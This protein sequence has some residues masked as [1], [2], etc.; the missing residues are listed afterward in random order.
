MLW[1]VWC[2]DGYYRFSCFR[3][4]RHTHTYANK[5]ERSLSR[6]HPGFSSYFVY[7][8]YDSTL[9][10]HLVYYHIISIWCLKYD[11][12]TLETSLH[13][14][15][16]HPGWALLLVILKMKSSRLLNFMFW[17]ILVKSSLVYLKSILLNS[18][19]QDRGLEYG[20]KSNNFDWRTCSL[21]PVQ[22]WHFRGITFPACDS[23]R[24]F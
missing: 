22:P 4:K 19:S 8:L 16:L 17:P 15:Y 6:W 24:Q 21:S 10:S 9:I 12:P 13:I 14:G 3:D 7:S 2:V 11:H 5:K 1:Y 23:W 18:T 20:L